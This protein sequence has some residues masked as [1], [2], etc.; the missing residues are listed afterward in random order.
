VTDPQTRQFYET[1]AAALAAEAERLLREPSATLHRAFPA[2]CRL[3]DVGCGCGAEVITLLNSGFDAYGTDASP[4]LLRAARDL[5]REHGTPAE[6]RFLLSELPGLDA[7]ADAE[8]DAVLCSAVLMHLPAEGL[9][10]AAYGLRRVLKPG[11]RLLVSIPAARADVA[12]DTRRDPRGRLFTDLP[13][14]KLILLLERIGFDLQWREDTLDRLNRPGIHWATLCFDLPAKGAERPLHQV[15][16]ILNRD[17]KDATYKL[18]LFRAL[19]ELAQTQTHLAEFLPDGRVA[20]PTRELALKW[21]YYYWPLLDADAYIAQKNGERPDCAKP[22]VV[23]SRLEPL[24]AAYAQRGGLTAFHADCTANRM[25]ASDL[26]LFDTA[27]RE[28]Q[29]TIWN[30]PA[31]YAGGGEDFSVFQYD[32]KQKALL[33]Q[34]ALWRELCL[35]GS[36]IADATLLRWAELCANFSR[37]SLRPSEVVDRLLVVPDT[38]RRVADARE[39]FLHLPQRFCVWTG[40]SLPRGFDV[41]HAIPFSLWRNN[42]LW[43]LFPAHA[44]INNQKRDSIPTWNLVQ[45]QRDLI[46]QV[47]RTLHEQHPHRFEREAMTLLGRETFDKSRWELLLFS[48]FAESMESTAIQRGSARWEPEGLRPARK[49]VPASRAVSPTPYPKPE[50][51]ALLLTDRSGGAPAADIPAPKLLRFED[52]QTQAWQTALPLVGGLA[53]GSAFH[54]F[55]IENLT[56]EAPDCDWMEIPANL[57]KPNRFV[58]QVR[59]DSMEPTLPQGSFA[60]FEYHRR[61]R[62]EGSIVIANLNELGTHHGTEAIKRVHITP[63]HWE[64]RS[65]NPVYP[66]FQVPL[67]EHPYPILGVFV[68]P[69]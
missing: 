68:G 28:F 16:S 12:P 11:G 9:F 4:E 66:P 59:G 41:D 17:K 25:T 40:A 54:G 64:F 31:R 29:R 51:E 38:E 10:D 67:E 14:E 46:I 22:T 53:A 47:W 37:G 36:W 58:V 42:D 57:A 20:I 55:D 1:H 33:M 7:F 39:V 30:M 35:T 45:H 6:G 15:E 61:P 18:A 23:R 24:V 69:L 52:I 26:A 19:A 65:D 50:P 5:A 21:I 43:N 2:P 62:Q 44:R 8:F 27:L 34:A 49:P 60:V 48:R 56:T 13:P 63:S 32:R 3:L